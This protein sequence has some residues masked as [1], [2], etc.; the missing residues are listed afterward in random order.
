[1]VLGITGTGSDKTEA[2]I[3]DHILAKF[4]QRGYITDKKYSRESKKFI[5]KKCCFSFDLVT[6]GRDS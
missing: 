6:K 5:L 1:M 4:G 3:V 2:Q